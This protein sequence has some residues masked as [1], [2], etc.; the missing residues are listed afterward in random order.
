[1][2]ESEQDPVAPAEVRTSCLVIVDESGAQR[3]VLDVERE[4]VQL[5]LHSA[6]TESLEILI[7]ASVSEPGSH[8][9][10]VEIWAHGECLASTTVEKRGTEIV[11]SS[12]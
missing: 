5:R 10:G 12:F 11:R 8:V 7:F 4:H 6:A 1:V 9:A 3:A 2:E